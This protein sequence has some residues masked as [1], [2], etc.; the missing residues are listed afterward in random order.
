MKRLN[1]QVTL[2]GKFE[3][4]SVS[5]LRQMP[6]EVLA[7][8][9]L[10]KTFLITKSGKPIAVLSKPPGTT[11]TLEVEPNGKINYRP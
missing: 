4:I 8:V 1:E 3:S 6:G 9:T 5:D 10:G 2:L 7:C 11:L